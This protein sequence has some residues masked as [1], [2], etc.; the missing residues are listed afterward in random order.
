MSS[1]NGVFVL[2]GPGGF[3]VGSSHWCRSCKVKMSIYVLEMFDIQVLLELKSC[4]LTIRGKE[5]ILP[6]FKVCPFLSLIGTRGDVDLSA[7]D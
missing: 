5:E 7:I 2:V 6:R 3:L 4:G 1:L